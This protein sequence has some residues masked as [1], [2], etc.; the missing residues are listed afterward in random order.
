VVTNV[1][2]ISVLV[3][4]VSGIVLFAFIIGEFSSYLLEKI[5]NRGK[6]KVIKRYK[7]SGHV[8][9]CGLSDKLEGV[10]RELRSE[11]LETHI[12]VVIISPNAGEISFSND[13]LKRGTFSIVGEPLETD[14]LERA[15]LE[16]ARSVLVLSTDETIKGSR[17]YRDAQVALVYNTVYNYLSRKD[18]VQALKSDINVVL[19]FLDEGNNLLPCAR[20]GENQPEVYTTKIPGSG[21]RLTVEPIYLENMPRYLF[22]QSIIDRDVNTVVQELVNS[23]DDT[24]E[25]YYRGV[26]GQL[27][28]KSFNSVE[29]ALLDTGVTPIGVLRHSSAMTEMVVSGYEGASRVELLLN[30]GADVKLAEGDMLVLVAYTEKDVNDAFRMLR[31]VKVPPAR[32]A[33][34]QGSCT[35]V[36]FNRIFIINWSASQILDTMLEMS[37]ICDNASRGSAKTERMEMVVITT[38]PMVELEME[39]ARI[40]EVVSE[41]LGKA[42]DDVMTVQLVCTAEP[43]SLKALKDAGISREA[44]T[45]SRV[46]IVSDKD[47]DGGS[48]LRALHQLQIIENRISD[49]VFTAVELT[50][51]RNYHY[52]RNTRAD[53][54][55]SIDA[56]AELMMAQAV[57]KPYVSLI[58]RN[59]LTFS[60]DTCEFYF[61]DVPE[62]YVGRTYR[63]VQKMLIGHPIILMGHARPLKESKG[64]HRRYSVTLNPRTSG[65]Y[66]DSGRASRILKSEKMARGDRL[67]LV[68][69]VPEVVDSVLSQMK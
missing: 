3:M 40:K 51:S 65:Q 61:R 25:F 36:P 58:F 64:R 62:N 5:I 55:V 39:L 43:I 7:G 37:K 56:F 57:L 10:M 48:D 30:P 60:E 32:P 6:V 34:G 45:T 2:K 19:E 13:S 47:S 20:G 21:R 1:G 63:D 8:V 31:T 41:K 28:G 59:L 69:R 29:L 27:A 44:A 22:I 38:R 54:I 26:G 49:S 46:L 24:C 15:N 9:I 16:G 12:P 66:D 14:S 52:F 50:D 4:M 18:K 11:A 53:V 33:V 17:M 67:I 68:A 42:I 23:Q 35:P